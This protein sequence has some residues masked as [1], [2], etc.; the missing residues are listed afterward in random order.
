MDAYFLSDGSIHLDE[1]NGDI[2]Q[3]M[4]PVTRLQP[5]SPM[6]VNAASDEASHASSSDSSDKNPDIP[7]SPLLMNSRALRASRGSSG[8]LIGKVLSTHH[9]FLFYNSSNTLLLLSVSFH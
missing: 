6:A 9:R 5:T 8:P 7:S 1:D 2:E 4:P 3:D